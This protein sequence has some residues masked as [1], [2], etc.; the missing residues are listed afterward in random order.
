MNWQAINFDWN[1]ARAFLATAQEGS[2]SAASRALG[3]TQPTIGRQVTALEESLGVTL[4]ERVGRSLV[5]TE[6]GHDLVKHVRGMG[7]AASKFSMAASGQSQQIDGHV[8]IT[9]A[10]ITSTYHLPPALKKLR[11]IAPGIEVT[12]VASNSIQNLMQREADIAIRHVRPTESE[13]FA[14]LVAETTGHL[15]ATPDYLERVGWPKTLEDVSRCDFIGFDDHDQLLMHLNNWGLSVTRKNIRY[16]S[17]NGLV[18]WSMI[19][20]GL[21]IGP[22]SRDAAAHAPEVQQVLPELSGPIPIWL[23]AHRELHTSKRIRLVFDVLAEQFS[24]GS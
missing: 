7:E 17:A 9:A 10:D 2:L 21:G 8:A 3:Q 16:S 20:H 15:Y 24:K 4:F 22:M 19:R 12:V 11:E 13:L 18:A 1:Q 5:L 23:V 14:R 6:A